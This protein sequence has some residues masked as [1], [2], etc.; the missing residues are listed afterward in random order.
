MVMRAQSLPANMVQEEDLADPDT[1][2]DAEITHDAE[3]TAAHDQS[4]AEQPD[5]GAHV[6]SVLC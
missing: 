1:A 6:E 3:N 2:A 4:P 5:D